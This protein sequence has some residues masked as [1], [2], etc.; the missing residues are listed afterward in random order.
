M[1]VAV[2][3][4]CTALSVD[5][6]D[7][8]AG[9]VGTVFHWALPNGRA[10]VMFGHS[11]L[12]LMFTGPPGGGWGGAGSQIIDTVRATTAIGQRE[13]QVTPAQGTCVYENPYVGKA[14]ITCDATAP[15]HHWHAELTSDGTPPAEPH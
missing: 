13:P 6:A 3:G 4:T 15:G 8:T 12:V 9:C 10:I 2:N 14:H 11:R 5:G 7:D 1:V